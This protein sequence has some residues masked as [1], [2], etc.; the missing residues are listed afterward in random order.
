MTKKGP[1]NLR[2]LLLLLVVLL[3]SCSNCALTSSQELRP[4]SGWRRMMRRVKSSNSGH[5]KGGGGRGDGCG[6]YHLPLPSPPPPLL[7][8]LRVPSSPPPSEAL[9]LP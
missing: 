1:L 5:G 8:P 2:L 9:S 3:L 4:L 6:V 7:P